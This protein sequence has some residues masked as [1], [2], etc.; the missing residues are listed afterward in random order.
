[1]SVFCNIV[2]DSRV[3]HTVTRQ[4]NSVTSVSRWRHCV[5]AGFRGLSCFCVALL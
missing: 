3:A 5:F 2:S 4:P 1:M